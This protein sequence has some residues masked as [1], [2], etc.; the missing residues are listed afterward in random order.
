M[1]CLNYVTLQGYYF[2]TQQ[3]IIAATSFR[4]GFL[5]FYLYCPQAH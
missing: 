2:L 4:N 1:L 3:K 5:A